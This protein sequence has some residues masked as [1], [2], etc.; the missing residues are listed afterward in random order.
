MKEYTA[1]QVWG[2]SAAVHR[3]NG[4]YYKDDQW[5]MNATPP[6]LDKKANKALVKE[7]LRTSNFVDVSQEDIAM[8]QEIRRHFQSYML[9]AITGQL[10]DFQKQA[11]RLAQLETFKSS[12]RLEVAIVSCL[13]SVFY[14]DTA[15]KE[16]SNIIR[17]AQQLVGTEG[18]KVTGQATVLSNSYSRQF[19]KY[20][21]QA[22]MGDSVV[23][24]WHTTGQ[25]VGNEITLSGKIKEQCGNNT[26]QLNYVKIL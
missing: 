9:L 16:V 12:D 10:N 14:R 15:R 3:I 20:R 8:G 2:V 21:I 22:K 19:N 26:T 23:T 11:Y 4:G 7:W 17:E 5:M 25:S 18:S 6:Y 1:E 24:F 13:P